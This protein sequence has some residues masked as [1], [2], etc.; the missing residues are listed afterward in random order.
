M[1][2]GEVARRAGT[3]TETIRFYERSGLLPPPERTESNYRVFGP[4]H[5]ERLEFIRRCRALGIGL[6]SVH[7]LLSFRDEPC[8]HC[9]GVNEILDG[10]IAQVAGQIAELRALQGQLLELRRSCPGVGLTADCAILRRLDRGDR[11][12]QAKEGR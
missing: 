3:S 11:P 8:G 2:I 1:K 7:D 5:V 10:R 4:R 9:E 12:A 6:G